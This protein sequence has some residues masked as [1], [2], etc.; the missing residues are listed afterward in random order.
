MWVDDPDFDVRRHV[1]RIAVPSPGGAQE[2]GELAGNAASTP[3]RPRR[4]LWE[5]WFIEGLAGG[6]IGVMMKYHHCLLDG[7]AGAS[8]A[9]V[10]LDLE[11]D[12]TEP[13][14]PPPTARGARP[15]APSRATCELLAEA[16]QTGDPAPV[17]DRALRR[18]P[19]P[20]RA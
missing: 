9:T 5:M 14:M 3:A 7:V 6:R 12:A 17:P 2:L 10:L 20:P 18:R 8:L 13:L 11:P 1:R 16:L 19:A 15:P 4:P